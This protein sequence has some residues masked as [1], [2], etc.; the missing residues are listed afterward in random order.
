MKFRITTIAVVAL[1]AIS[2]PA[3]FARI[4]PDPAGLHLTLK[5]AASIHVAKHKVA[6]KAKTGSSG[7]VLI[8]V[9]PIQNPSAS[10]PS[11]PTTNCEMYM[12]DCTPEQLCDWWGENCSDVQTPAVSVDSQPA[13]ASSAPAPTQT[14]STNDA[15]SPDTTATT[16]TGDASAST[17]AA[18]D[19]NE[20]C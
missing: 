10:L 12:T 14:Y 7:R 2:A 9:A 8:I 11:D 3:A 19:D 15:S 16:Q 4:A 5:H 17:A 18:S 1:L 20:D 13:P 6:K